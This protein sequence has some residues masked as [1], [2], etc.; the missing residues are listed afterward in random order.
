MILGITLLDIYLHVG[1]VFEKKIK[2]KN[3]FMY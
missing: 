3:S 2:E 1:Y